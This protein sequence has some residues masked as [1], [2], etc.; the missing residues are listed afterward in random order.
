MRALSRSDQPLNTGAK[1]KKKKKGGVG[2]WGWMGG[3]VRDGVGGEGLA[4]WLV[5]LH[6][7][8]EQQAS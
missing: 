8:G 3:D 7:Q 4:W 6:P 1:K 2:G 5:H